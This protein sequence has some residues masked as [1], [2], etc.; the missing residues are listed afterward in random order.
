MKQ[1]VHII[2]KVDFEKQYIKGLQLEVDYELATL[3]DAIQKN[4]AKQMSESKAR[5]AEIHMELE[6]FHAFA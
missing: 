4:D 2:R 5:L 6:A 1:V 3:Y